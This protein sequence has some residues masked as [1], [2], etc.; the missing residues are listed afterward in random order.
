MSDEQMI[1][2]DFFLHVEPR[3]SRGKLKAIHASRITQTLQ[4]GVE[5]GTVAL[6][7]TVALPRAVFDPYVPDVR[8]E[9]SPDLV[10]AHVEAGSIPVLDAEVDA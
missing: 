5:A 6:R 7:V 9:V 8:I 2:A 3:F 10:G 1:E 4:R